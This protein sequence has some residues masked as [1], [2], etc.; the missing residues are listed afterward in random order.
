MR[1]QRMDIPV[2]S[3]TDVVNIGK[4]NQKVCDS[5]MGYSVYSL[6]CS[7]SK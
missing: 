1:Q 4:G 6:I 2:R 5:N 7:K 3:F